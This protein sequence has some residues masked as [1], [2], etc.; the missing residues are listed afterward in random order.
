MPNEDQPGSVF[1]VTA[2]A[3]VLIAGASGV[4]MLVSARCGATQGARL[5][6]RLQWEERRTEIDKAVAQAKAEGKL[7]DTESPLDLS[8]E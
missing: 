8:N 2:F 3:M 4:F 1:V 6:K 7:R 5:S